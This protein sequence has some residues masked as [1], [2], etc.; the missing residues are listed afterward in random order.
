MQCFEWSRVR[1]AIG[2]WGLGIVY[3][4][5][6][7]KRETFIFKNGDFKRVVAFFAIAPMAVLCTW[8]AYHFRS[9]TGGLLAIVCLGFMTWAVS[10]KCRICNRRYLLAYINGHFGSDWFHEIMHSKVC[11]NANCPSRL[12][13][14]ADRAADDLS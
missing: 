11:L 8:L 3:K 4:S 7:E 2:W 14:N 1:V 6:Q 5:D 13:V 9:A 10:G 12:A